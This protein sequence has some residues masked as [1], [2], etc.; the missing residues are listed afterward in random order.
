[1]ISVIYLI[2]K[3]VPEERMRYLSRDGFE[4]EPQGADW[5]I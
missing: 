5:G 3:R 2:L 4:R 1:M